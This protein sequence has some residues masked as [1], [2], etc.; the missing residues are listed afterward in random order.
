MSALALDPMKR[1]SDAAQRAD[2]IRGF[3]RIRIVERAERR[4]SQE[5]QQLAVQPFDDVFRHLV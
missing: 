1:H 4:R 3:R 2:R 5:G